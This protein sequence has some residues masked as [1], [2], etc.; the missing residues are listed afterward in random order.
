MSLLTTK[1][2]KLEERG[3]FLCSV[4]SETCPVFSLNEKVVFCN[5]YYTKSTCTFFFCRLGVS[6]WVPPR[7]NLSRN[8]APHRCRQL[9]RHQT[10]A[11]SSS[12]APQFS[13][14]ISLAT[15]THFGA[16]VSVS[17]NSNYLSVW[18]VCLTNTCPMSLATKWDS[19]LTVH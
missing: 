14:H 9:H 18:Q 6:L 11:S 19:V 2:S 15:G 16:T 12:K 7:N 1:W 10:K 8:S 5:P 13:T 4:C 17:R 3:E